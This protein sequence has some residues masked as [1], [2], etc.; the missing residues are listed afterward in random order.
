MKI[1]KKL[2]NFRN[3]VFAVKFSIER[4]SDDVW[5]IYNIMNL[6]DFITGKCYRRVKKETG[7]LIKTE[8]KTMT[9]TLQIKS[10]QY[11][12]QNDTI[13]ISGINATENKNIGLGQQQSMDIGPDMSITLVKKNFDSIHVQRLN[14]IQKEQD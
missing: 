6:D 2:I 13:R 3:K 14:Q 1:L 9:C 4:N 11:D 10:F 5:N 8:N 12:E 7:Q